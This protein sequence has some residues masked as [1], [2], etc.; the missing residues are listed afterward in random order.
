MPKAARL[1]EIALRP[2]PAGATLSHWLYSEIR[3]AIIEERASPG[4]LLPASRALAARYG[5][6]RG[7]VVTVYEQLEA[8]GY[9]ES[10][11]GSGTVVSARLPEQFLQ[12][13]QLCNPVRIAASKCVPSQ[14]SRRGAALARSPYALEQVRTLGAAFRAN[15]PSIE[16]FPLQVWMRL[17]AR[18]ARLSDRA[19]LVDGDALGFYPL[20]RAISNWVGLARGVHCSPE[21]VV[22]LP[23]T[24]QALNHIA[25]LVLD[26]GD[27]VWMEDPGFIGAHAAFNAAGA[28]IVPVSVDAQGLDVAAAEQLAPGARLAYVT[29]AHSHPLGRTMST[30]RRLALLG[31]AQRTGAWI[32]EDDY[33]GEFRFAGR[34]L[35]ALQSLDSAGCTIYGASFGK[36]LFP[37]LRISFVVAPPRLVEPLRNLRSLTDRY[38]ALLSQAVLTDFIVEGHFEQH[39][40]RMRTL[41]AERRDV[42][43]ECARRYWQGRLDVETTPGGL[44]T[45][46]WLA[47]GLVDTEVA[48]AATAANV[49]LQPLSRRALRPGIINGLQLGFATVPPAEIRQ[50]AE[51]LAAVLEKIHP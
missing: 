30:E 13:G 19:L 24:Q 50:G 16:A 23:G 45:V 39:M 34:P 5:V 10:R 47:D 42:L 2:P 18:R 31:W 29:P 7:T 22:V 44:Q 33:D 37:S 40:R 9:I 6:A 27:A 41:Y 43:L 35:A 49:E 21:Q 14:L 4:T 36:L 15:Q 11:R 46:G 32:F 12:T 51:R 38:Q 1:Q 3:A 48:A 28:R 20:R 17:A 26:P 8:E 25:R